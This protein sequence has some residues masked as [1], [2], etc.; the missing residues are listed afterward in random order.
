LS[1]TCRNDLFRHLERP[2]GCLLPATPDGDIMARMTND[3]N[4]VRML[5][6]PAIM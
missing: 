3:L 6:G 4:A 1:S 5:L 2:A